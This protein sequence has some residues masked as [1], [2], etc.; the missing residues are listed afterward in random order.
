MF[1]KLPFALW[2]LIFGKK[3]FKTLGWIG[4]ATGITGVFFMATRAF[5]L[6]LLVLSFF[7]LVYLLVEYMRKKQKSW[8]KTAAYYIGALFLAYLAFSGTQ[9]YVYPQKKVNRHTQGVT[10]QLATINTS[11]ASINVRLQSWSWSLDLLK[12]KPLFGIGSGNW[13]V[14]VLKYENQKT[15]N[16]EYLN[17]VVSLCFPTINW[18]TNAQAI[19][20]KI[21]R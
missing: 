11:D 21:P 15:D 2:L 18:R 20:T 16:Y 13:K 1:V 19:R 12:E 14:A 10:Q 17:K 3:W 6:G 4:L 9:Q 8:L 7:L 5:Y